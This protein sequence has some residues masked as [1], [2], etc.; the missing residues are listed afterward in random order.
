MRPL[1]A[2]WPALT[3]RLVTHHVD[4]GCAYENMAGIDSLPPSP[5]IKPEVVDSLAHA[6]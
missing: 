5:R 1:L 3:T 6:S 4:S 2:T